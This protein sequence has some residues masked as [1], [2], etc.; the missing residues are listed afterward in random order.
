LVWSLGTSVNSFGKQ[1]HILQKVPDGQLIADAFEDL[2]RELDQ[3]QHL[4][5]KKP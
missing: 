5:W 3:A 4:I 1:H 2:W